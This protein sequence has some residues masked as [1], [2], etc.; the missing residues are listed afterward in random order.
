M[1]EAVRSEPGFVFD[2]PVRWGDLDAMNHVNNTVYFR[3]IE[4]ARA[5]LML[6]LGLLPPSPRT[7]VLAHASLD[8]VRPVLYPATVRVV[9][10]LVRMGRS[11]FEVEVTVRDAGQP[12]LIYARGRNVLVSVSPQGGSQPWSEEEIPRIRQ[13]FGG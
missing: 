4:E 13:A 6:Q 12:E 7:G 3:Y 8:F 5:Q 11:S 9:H 2:I 1:S 10:H